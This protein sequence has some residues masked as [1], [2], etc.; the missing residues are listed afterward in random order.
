MSY[1]KAILGRKDLSGTSESAQDTPKPSSQHKSDSFA[2]VGQ[3]AEIRD[4][5]RK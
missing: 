4:K 5:D 2:P 1:P 3:R